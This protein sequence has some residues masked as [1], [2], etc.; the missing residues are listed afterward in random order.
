MSA[1]SLHGT[2]ALAY[3]TPDKAFLATD[4]KLS[5]LENTFASLGQICKIRRSGRFAVAVSGF[6]SNSNTGFDAWELIT[7]AI[8]NAKSVNAAATLAEI[9]VARKLNAAL[10]EA[11]AKAPLQFAQTFR[12]GSYMTFVI[13]GVDQ[14]VPTWEVRAFE[15]EGVRKGRQPP[16]MKLKNVGVGILNFGENEAI[17]ARLPGLENQARFVLADPPKR[18]FDLI[19]LEAQHVPTKVGPPVSILEINKTGFYWHSLGACSADSPHRQ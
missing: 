6:Y 15:V 13:A 3:W 17:E 9:A 19:L 18:L 10:A 2:A 11:Q 4:S 5:S 16:S 14:G 1:Q 8:P 12:G 7:R